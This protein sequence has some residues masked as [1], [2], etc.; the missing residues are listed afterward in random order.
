LRLIAALGLAGELNEGAFPMWAWS[1]LRL[2]LIGTAFLITPTLSHADCSVDN[3]N[4]DLARSSESNQPSEPNVA[5]LR[6]YLCRG[7]TD[8]KSPQVRVE[9]HRL[10]DGAASI[11][12]QKQSSAGLEKVFGTPRIVENDVFKTYIDLMNRF[13]AVPEA[14]IYPTLRVE[15]PRS[16]EKQFY[17]DQVNA[18]GIKALVNISRGDGVYN[19]F[20]PAANEIDALRTRSLPPS[21]K[22]FYNGDSTNPFMTFWRSLGSEDVTNYS[23]NAGA[24][25]RLLRRL[26]GKKHDPAGDQSPNVPT[27]LKLLQY[28]AGAQWPDDFVVMYAFVEAKKLAQRSSAEDEGGCG[29]E[30]IANLT[31]EIPYPTIIVD[32][33]LIENISKAPVKI[34]SLHGRRSSVSALRALGSDSAALT[35]ASFE[36]SRMLAPGERLLVPTRISFVPQVWDGAPTTT[37][38]ADWS[39]SMR[40]SSQIQRR[41]GTSGLRANDANH[42]VPLLRTYLF[43]PELSIAGLTVNGKVVNFEQRSANFSDLVRSTEGL[44][45]P[46]LVSWDATSGTW[47][48]HG[49]VLDKAPNQAREYTDAKSVAGFRSRF[50]IEEREPEIAF[51]KQ[52][53]LVATLNNGVEIT[54]KPSNVVAVADREGDY[55]SLYWN[56]TVEFEF[57]LPRDIAEDQIVTSRF[58]VTGHYRRYSALLSKALSSGL[59]PIAISGR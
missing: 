54:L 38:G 3:R 14:D 10:S 42:A 19:L 17:T 11:L 24:F 9:F 33:L 45:C 21:L 46:Y 16:E 35:D 55:L 40:A 5:A 39:K 28:V 49:K 1:G 20:Y 29:D 8:P 47:T 50:R 18:E 36:L 30:V 59:Q 34:N 23:A 37:N 32:T 48:E 52:V 51:I 13:G 2:I 22:Y 7:E 56:Q 41:M 6:S 4:V 44:S 15:V 58:A 12:L 25:N 43:G 57:E 27:M 26:R 53:E 31:F